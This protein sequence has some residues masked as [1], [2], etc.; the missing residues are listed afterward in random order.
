MEGNNVL[1]EHNSNQIL[2]SKSLVVSEDEVPHSTQ[3][4]QKPWKPW[5]LNSVTLVSIAIFTGGLAIVLGILQWQ[6]ARYGALFFAPT[7]DGFSFSENFLYRY[8]PTIIIVSYGLAWSWIDLDIKRLEPWFQLAHA[9]GASAEESLLLQYPVDFL[10]LV[11]F[12]AAKLRL[13]VILLGRMDID[14]LLQGN[15]PSSSLQQSWS[16]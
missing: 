11:P 3:E 15:G 12:K 14:K 13:V 4:P 16:S 8:L 7:V 10:P 9:E 5:T 1:S 2:S 6:N